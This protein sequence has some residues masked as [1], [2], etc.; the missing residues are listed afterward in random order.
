MVSFVLFLCSRY[1]RVTFVR[2]QN[3]VALD[4]KQMPNNAG[5]GLGASHSNNLAL[6]YPYLIAVRHESMTWNN[7]SSILRILKAPTPSQRY[8]R[9]SI[10][11]R[12]IPDLSEL[13]VILPVRRSGNLSCA[14][15]H[16]VQVH[17][18]ALQG[19]LSPCV[20]MVSR[21]SAPACFFS[22]RALRISSHLPHRSSLP[23]PLEDH[24]ARTSAHSD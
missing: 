21:L 1:V 14:H 2:P 13:T 16:C 10:L 9:W 20:G 7:D 18:R 24:V 12:S 19:V 6:T 23:R 11:A 15:T 4:V 3:P 5:C 22:Y 17:A 8:K